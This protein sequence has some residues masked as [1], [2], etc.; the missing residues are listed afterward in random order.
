MVFLDKTCI[1]QTD[2]SLKRAG[3]LKL[4]AFLTSSS[5][6]L[7]LYSDVYLKKLWTVYEVACFLLTPRTGNDI[8]ILHINLAPFYLLLLAVMYISYNAA[9]FL[10]THSVAW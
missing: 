4:G 10:T 9:P 6:M 5:R 1:H 2:I 8:E 3:V 7:I